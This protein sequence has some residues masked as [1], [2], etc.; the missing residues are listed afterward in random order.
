MK[1][2]VTAVFVSLAGLV[3]S[4]NVGSR[5]SCAQAD[6]FGDPTVTPS[7]FKAGDV[8]LYHPDHN[9]TKVN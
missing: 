2:A 3:A 4:A 8:S 6:R 7:T 1:L 9:I 5:A